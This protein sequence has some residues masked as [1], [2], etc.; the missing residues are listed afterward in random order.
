MG[1]PHTAL[2]AEAGHE[3]GCAE[4]REHRGAGHAHAQRRADAGGQHRCGRGG[5]RGVHRCV[6][7]SR[8]AR[9]NGGGRDLA[10]QGVEAIEERL[11]LALGLRSG[12]TR[13]HAPDDGVAGPA[14]CASAPSSAATNFIAI[15]I[16]VQHIIV[17]HIIVQHISTKKREFS[18]P[19]SLCSP[20]LA[21]VSV[22]GVVSGTV[23]VSAT[24]TVHATDTAAV[25][26]TLT[27]TVTTTV[28]ITVTITVTA[29]R[30]V[31]VTDTATVS[32]IDIPP[33]TCSLGL[34]LARQGVQA[35]QLRLDLG[36]C[37]R[38]AAAAEARATVAKLIDGVLTSMPASLL[39]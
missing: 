14:P 19:F 29:T 33:H 12:Q 6:A 1:G 4:L 13:A 39:S 11:H 28:T 9:R 30:I 34:L 25:K 21:V 32:A 8:A 15:N 38:G 31:T 35:A 10:L 20:P 26:I 7:P 27:I 17:Q 3:A 2:A 5:H 22:I 18:S 37:T 23:T 36:R 24:V 16:I